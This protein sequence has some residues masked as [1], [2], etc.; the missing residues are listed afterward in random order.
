MKPGDLRRF[1]EGAFVR[2]D[3]H[4]N[5]KIFLVLSVEFNGVDI[6]MDGE[7]YEGWAYSVLQYNSEPVDEAR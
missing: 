3:R 7:M 4:F 6:L 5:G 1:L 2:N